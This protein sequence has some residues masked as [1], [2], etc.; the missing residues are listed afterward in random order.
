MLRLFLIC[1][2]LAALLGAAV[3]WSMSGEDTTPADFTFINRQDH[4]TLDPGQMSWLQDLR[5]AYALWEGLYT[6]D[7]KTLRPVPGVAEQLDIDPTQK[8]YTFHLRPE[9]RWSNGDPVLAGDFVFSWRRMLEQPA[10]YTE[11]Y[12]YIQGAKQYEEAYANWVTQADAATGPIPPP[13]DFTQVGIAAL[14]DHTL[15]VTLRNPT[16]FFLDLCAFPPFFPL[17]EPSMRP[18]AK[19]DDKTGRVAYYDQGFTRPPNLISNG[20]Y[21][22]T[23]WVFKR[24][25]RMVA[26]EQY[27]NPTSVHCKI[28]DEPIIDDSLACVR[29]YMSGQVDWLSW[30]DDDLI[31]QMRKAGGYNDLHI[32]KG[33]GTEFYVLNCLPNLPDGGT[34]PLAD[35]RVRRALAM[36]IDKRP[37]VENATKAGQPVALNYIPPG[38]FKGYTSPAGLPFDPVEARRL[39]AEAGYPNGKGF[40]AL[41]I[42]FNK[43]MVQ[44]ADVALII[45]NQ[46]RANLNIPI[47]LEQME[48]KVFADRLHHHD[49]AIA[50]ADWIG[51]YPDPTTFTDKFKS[52]NDDNNAAWSNADYDRLCAEAETETD[53]H[54]RLNL[55]SQAESILLQDAPVIPLYYYVDAYMFSSRV[56]GIELDPRDMVLFQAITVNR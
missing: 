39:L 14:D 43:E 55:L 44:R 2:V 52:D 21:R 35:P 17:H 23:E 9:A 24:K 26:N 15:Q 4:K 49:L 16:P 11:L 22:L 19:V 33:F 56:K 38:V 3:A 28:I 45:R 5:I 31:G 13:P 25:L 54:K 51:D 10:D 6:L 50:R 37:I 40:P 20:P 53:P 34:N 47:D 48:V 36:A 42:S 30:V 41:S 32:F 27:W 7:G 8:I 12:F 29:A 1:L 18:Y 46:W